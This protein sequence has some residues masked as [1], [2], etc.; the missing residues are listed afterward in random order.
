MRKFCWLLSFV[1]VTFT[2]TRPS[3]A[4]IVPE[5]IAQN[6][7]DDSRIDTIMADYAQ[8]GVPGASV[9]VIKDGQFLHAK[10]YGLADVEAKVGAMATTNYRLA[11]LTKQFT[12]MAIMILKE[13][14][15]IS[16]DQTITD[17]LPEFPTYGSKITIRN[18]LNHTSGLKDY[19]DLIP[20]STD[21]QVSD[22]DVL[23][24]YEA[25]SSG[26]FEPGTQYRYCNGGYVT[27]GVIIARLSGQSYPDFLRDHIFTPLTMANTVAYVNGTNQVS[28]RAYGYTADGSTFDRTDQS[29]TSATLGDGGIYTSVD[30]YSKWDAA[31]YGSAL[32]SQTTLAEAFT[33]GHLNDGSET[34]YGFGWMLDTYQGVRRIYHTGSSIGFRNAVNRFPDQHLTVIVLINRAD[35]SPSDLANQISDLYLSPS[36]R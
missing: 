12:A 8:P 3:F 26:D 28:N 15:K 6:I 21:G 18:L 22:Q 23:H 30:E 13:Q 27:L 9:A 29:V 31:L 7:P 2:A 11:S 34:G 5:N 17:L 14:G 24:L 25:Q 20:A 4:Q 1:A 16:Y 35:A 32:V 19:E 33:S 10:G 36:A